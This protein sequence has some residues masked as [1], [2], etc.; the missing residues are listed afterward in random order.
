MSKGK[1]T[2]LVA[3]SDIQRKDVPKLD[4]ARTSYDKKVSTAVPEANRSDGLTETKREL[5][6]SAACVGSTLAR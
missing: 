5:R 6:K 2:T 1:S 4:L 3:T